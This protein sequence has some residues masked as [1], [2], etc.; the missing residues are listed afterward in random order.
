[1]KKLLCVLIVVL[2]ALTVFS[3]ADREVTITGDGT[4]NSA[5]STTDQEKDVP[6]SIDF[7]PLTDTAEPAD[8]AVTSDTSDIVSDTE[9]TEVTSDTE[10]VTSEQQTTAD[11]TPPTPVNTGSYSSDP[12]ISRMTFLG[13][14]TTYGLKIYGIV[15]DSQ[16]WTPSNGTLAIFRATTDYIVDPATGGEYLIGDLC[17]L[18]KPDILVITLGVN[19]ISFMDEANFKS[20]YNLLIN[21]VKEASPSTK[22]AIQT[23]YPLSASYD[24]SSGINNEKIANGNLWIQQIA[25][26]QGIACI[27]SAS[28]LVDSSGYR[29]EAW[30]NGDGLHMSPAGFAVVMD[31]IINNPCY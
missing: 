21:T 9:Q 10:E 16:V 23:M 17:S 2:V 5:S 3:C 6:D 25:A 29:P 7:T 28:V 20:H 26:E 24:T 8:T 4:E 27:N 12:L 13:D 19:G 11:T 31:Y 22:I 18:R 30:Q 1:M 14:S 15:G